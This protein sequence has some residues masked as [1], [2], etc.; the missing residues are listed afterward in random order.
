MSNFLEEEKRDIKKIN[1]AKLEVILKITIGILIFNIITYVIAAQF[2][3]FDFGIFLEIITLIFVFIAYSKSK[4]EFISEAKTNIIIAILP[5][6]LLAIYD[7]IYFCFN[8]NELVQKYFNNSYYFNIYI[9]DISLI[10]VIFLLVSS[11]KKL[12]K[13]S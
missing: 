2:K 11:Y 1:K 13:V 6:S 5:I 12:S 10:L 4:R 3:L 7:F 9:I 8:H